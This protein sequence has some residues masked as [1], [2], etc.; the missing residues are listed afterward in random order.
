VPS[1]VWLASE[2]QI[3]VIEDDD[4]LLG[5][6]QI[7]YPIPRNMAWMIWVEYQGVLLWP[8]STYA[9]NLNTTNLRTGVNDWRSAPP[10]TPTQYA[11]EG[12]NIIFNPPPSAAA[13]ANAPTMR[14]RWIGSADDGLDVEGTPS[15][16]DM[17][18][19]LVRYDAAIGWL[20]AH[21]TQDNAAR[22]AAYTAEIN[23]RLPAAR[24]RWQNPQ[25]SYYPVFSPDTSSRWYAAR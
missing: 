17:D 18:Q 9:M 4:I 10:G 19:Q 3:D 14:W 15:L 11:I 16:S 22:I 6:N 23:R 8:T 5:V 21:P 20:S 12:R 2:L 7:E 1:L 24:K 25:M 13:I